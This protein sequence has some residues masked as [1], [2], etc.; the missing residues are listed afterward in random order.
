MSKA[1]A[2]ILRFI[3]VLLAQI[4][5]FGLI[6]LFGCVNANIYLLALLLL[7]LEIPRWLQYIIAFITGFIVDMFAMTYGVHAFSCVL[8][9]FIRP[10]LVNALNGRPNDDGIEKLGPG[11]KDFRW[12][13]LYT[14]ILVLIH[15]FS[16]VMLEAFTFRHFGRTLLVILG[17]TV[18]TTVLILCFEY[19]FTP[20]KKP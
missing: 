15:Q 11:D 2:N 1:T 3:V 8:M 7:P 14:L 13:L 10:Y 19:I 17:N 4:F 6:H 16:A 9:M 12:L 18:F 20:V 5:V